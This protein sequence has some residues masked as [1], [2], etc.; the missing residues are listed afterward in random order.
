MS[1]RYNDI[2]N[3]PERNLRFH[4][5][6]KVFFTKN[7][8]LTAAEKKLLGSTISKMEI[9]AQINPL[10]S[11]IVEVVN[12]VDSYENI[13]IIVCDIEDTLLEKVA[14]KCINLIQKYLPQQAVV[15]VEDDSGFKVNATHKRINQN[16]K[17]K[18]TIESS[19]TTCTL[20]KLYKN[21][22]NDAFYKALDFSKLD[23]TNLELL[24]KSYIQAIVQFNAASI[25]GTY[26]K[27]SNARTAQDMEHLAQIEHI[28]RDIVSLSSQIKKESQ[29]NN[30]VQLNILIKK[31][32]DR[33]DELKQ[34]LIA[35]SSK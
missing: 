35:N 8:S 20:S 22:L 25:T 21:E 2:L 33:I 18:L 10:T 13:F 11:N 29:L 24:Y 14:E 9:L 6:T 5:L 16:D 4:K 23:K 19:F 12:E 34:M 30:K 27:R 26:Q 3:I 7:Y 15:I 1:F 28:E 32:R 31:N 17:S